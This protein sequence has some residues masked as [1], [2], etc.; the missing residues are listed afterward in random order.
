MGGAGC[1]MKEFKAFF[2]AFHDALSQCF[3]IHRCEGQDAWRG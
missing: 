2:Q 1:L 3:F